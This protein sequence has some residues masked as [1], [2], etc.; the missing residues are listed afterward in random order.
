MQLGLFDPDHR[1]QSVSGET[2]KTLRDDESNG[3][4]STTIQKD[5]PVGLSTELSVRESS[6][7]A[8]QRPSR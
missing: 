4:L 7:A 8:V 6:N 3:D 1:K 2:K 5:R